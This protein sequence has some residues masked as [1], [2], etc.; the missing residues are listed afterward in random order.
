MQI[1]TIQNLDSRLQIQKVLEPLNFKCTCAFHLIFCVTC[2]QVTCLFLDV[3][4]FMFIAYTC[5]C[6]HCDYVCNVHYVY[7]VIVA[8]SIM[9]LVFETWFIMTS[10]I[11]HLVV[12]SIVMLVVLGLVL[13]R[14]ARLFR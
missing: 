2:V 1:G 9:M 7:I 11:I 14:L 5:V 3:L 10:V 6:L 8:M 13:S 4:M 12:T